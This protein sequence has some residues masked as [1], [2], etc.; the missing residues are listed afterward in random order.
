M[1]DL[2]IVLVDDHPMVRAGLRSVLEVLGG[3]TI[4]GE[5]ADGE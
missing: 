2:S 4:V 5:A 3:A 1:S